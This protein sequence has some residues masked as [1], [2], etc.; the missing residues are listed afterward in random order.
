MMLDKTEETKASRLG[1]L[2]LLQGQCNVNRLFLAQHNYDTQLLCLNLS[3][4]GPSTLV[5]RARNLPP[6]PIRAVCWTGCWNSCIP[7]RIPKAS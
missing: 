3:L 4:A 6:N 1:R 2:T 7:G 5:V